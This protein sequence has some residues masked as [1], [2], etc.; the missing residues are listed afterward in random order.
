ME[1]KQEQKMVIKNVLIIGPLKKRQNSFEQIDKSKLW[2]IY[3]NNKSA[4]SSK[5]KN[6]K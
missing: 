5:Y 6:V 4:F 3:F 2:L 1:I